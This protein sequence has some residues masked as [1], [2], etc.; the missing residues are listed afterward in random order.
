MYTSFY[1]IIV[2]SNKLYVRFYYRD[3]LPPL[4]FFQTNFPSRDRK[5][6]ARPVG[7]NCIPW[8]AEKSGQTRNPRMAKKSAENSAIVE[9]RFPGGTIYTG[10]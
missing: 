1:N 9:S 6:E 5:K 4:P 3:A 2:V 7:I 8:M 10:K